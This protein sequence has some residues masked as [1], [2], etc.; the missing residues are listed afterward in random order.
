MH[1]DV[2]VHMNTLMHVLMHIGMQNTGTDVFCHS[3]T[4]HCAE[5]R[6]LA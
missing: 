6:S 5:T 2:W 4:L 3:P 1:T